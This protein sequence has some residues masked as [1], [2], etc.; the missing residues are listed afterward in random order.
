MLDKEVI[1][2]EFQI[3]PNI[4][5][6]D[7]KNN[8]KPSYSLGRTCLYT[9][10]DS[11]KDRINLLLIP[12]YLCYSVAEVP[13]RLNVP[14]KHYHVDL[15]FEPNASSIKQFISDNPNKTAIVLISYFGMV[16]LDKT[17]TAIRNEYPDTT[18]I[19]D[20]VQNYY[21]LT[22]HKDYDY[23]FTSL[24]KWF[25]VP[26]GAYILAKEE[27]NYSKSLFSN[28]VYAAYK[29]SGNLLKNHKDII[30][31]DISL[32]LIKFGEELMDKEYRYQCS[33]LS[34]ELIKHIDTDQAKS[35]RLKN[36]K[37]LHDGLTKLGIN[38][39]YDSDS[40]P[41]FIPIITEKRDSI[42]SMLFENKIFCPI[43]WPVTDTKSQGENELYFK[44]LS[45]ICDQRYDET[46]ME[47]VLQVLV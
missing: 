12:D 41:L 7:Y 28:P 35:V 21:G 44:E 19:I 9:I 5:Y 27:S 36:A 29:A 47:R 31:D 16:K 26:D 25:S 22:S 42:R 33:D 39:L 37:F 20:D 8:L 38:H 18:I 24:R 13:K 10:L 34:K 40:V 23:C 4:L 17:I 3:D 14:F 32:E 2:G 15:S 30:G 43:H 6:W 11:V 45:L 1:G 46:D